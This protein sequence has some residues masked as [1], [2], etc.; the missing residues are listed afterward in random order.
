LWALELAPIDLVGAPA[1]Q[2]RILLIDDDSFMLEMQSRMLRSM[3][4]EMIGTVGSAEVA[5]TMLRREPQAVVV[6]VCDLN[7]L[8]IDGIEFL[9]RLNASAFRGSIILLSGEGA[10]IMHTVRKLLAGGEFVIL[11][12]LEKPARRNAPRALLD[13]WKRITKPGRASPTFRVMAAEMHAANRE[14]QWVLHISP[15]AT[16][17]PEP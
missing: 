6:I 11:G 3:G 9:R 7:M 10:R 8:G 17:Q 12:A 15:K 2:P 1:S 14:S 4:Y 13:G 16:S 5:L